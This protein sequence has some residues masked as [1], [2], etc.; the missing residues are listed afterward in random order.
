MIRPSLPSRRLV[1]ALLCAAACARDVAAQEPPEPWQ[2]VGSFRGASQI[3]DLDWFRNELFRH[4]QRET[5]FKELGVLEPSLG[6]SFGDLNAEVVAGFRR[7]VVSQHDVLDPGT[8]VSDEDL[9]TYRVVNSSTTKA[10]L[11]LDYVKDVIGPVDLGFEVD[12]GF[13]MAIARSQETYELGDQPLKKVTRGSFSGQARRYWERHVKRA[14]GKMTL[15]TLRSLADLVDLL[16]GSIARPFVDTEKGAIFVEGYVEP[17]T[18]YTELGVP[19]QASVFTAADST[20]AVGDSVTYTAFLGLAPLVANFREAGV[21]SSFQHFYRFVRQTTVQKEKNNQVLVSVQTS[22]QIGNELIPLKIRPELRWTILR[23]GYTLFNLQFDRF[24]QLQS[25]I[26]YRV[27]LSN[28]QGMEAFRQLLGQG[29]RVRFRPLLEAAQK[30]EGARILSTEYRRGRQVRD[31]LRIDLPGWLRLRRTNLST[32]NRVQDYNGHTTLE[33]SRLHYREWKNDLGRRRNRKFRSTLTARA[34]PEARLAA[35]G[36]LLKADFAL[37][38]STSVS[39]RRARSEDVNRLLAAIDQALDLPQSH[40]LLAELRAAPFAGRE[41]SASLDLSF[42]GEQLLKAMSASEEQLWQELAELLLGRS[43]RQAW[44][45]PELRYRFQ[46]EHH[47]LDGTQWRQYLHIEPDPLPPGPQGR[48]AHFLR[49]PPRDSRLLFER[50]DKLVARFRK[51]QQYAERPEC[52]RC[53]TDL[54]SHPEDLAALQTLLVRLSGGIEGGGVGYHFEIFTDRMSRP[55]VAGNDIRYGFKRPPEVPLLNPA[56]TVQTSPPRLQ[57]G[58]LYARTGE[59]GD[60]DTCFRLELYSDLR[61]PETMPLR[62]DLRK[63]SA[64]ADPSLSIQLLPLGEPQD[65]PESPF[66]IARYRYEIPLPRLPKVEA[67]RGYTFA[68]RVLNA[69]GVPVTEER[70]LRFRLSDKLAPAMPAACLPEGKERKRAA[71][72]PAKEAEAVL[73]TH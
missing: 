73:A 29:N 26:T 10:K 40:P 38:L 30:T 18:L 19:L 12:S 56:D 34:D 54:Y 33:A 41:I 69:S 2:R 16:L 39:D 53:L 22:V 52:L 27:D 62:L 42:G 45:T 57:A 28:E 58:Q 66:R 71:E 63:Q 47:M 8:T 17:I 35:G 25:E 9:S 44:S 31:R 4:E 20:L 70:L 55:L 43:Y 14:D 24:D 23:L 1:L 13:S 49:R 48:P 59:A 50:A 68:L 21:R 61:F 65:V 72:R 46:L 3:Q 11:R 60:N 5:L 32:H 67:Q 6:N 7:R 15:F 36:D 64:L 37:D 51:L